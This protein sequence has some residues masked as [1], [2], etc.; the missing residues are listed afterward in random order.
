MKTSIS[1]SCSL[2]LLLSTAPAIAQ[3]PSAAPSRPAS[4]PVGT[5][6]ATTTAP[7]K[8]SAP[9]AT[10]STTP[11]APPTTPAA[12]ATTPATTAPATPA[13]TT[14]RTAATSADYRLVPGD[15]LR[16]EVYKDPQLSQSVQ[17]RPDGKITLP[18][19]NDVTAAGQTPSELRDAIVTS[20]KPYMSNPT[21]T[22]MVVETVP[23]LIY[24]MGE[25]NSA[26][27]QPLVGKMDVLQALAAAK[28]FRDFADTKNIVI[29]RGSQVLTFNYND[30]IKGK[31]TPVYLQPGD[32]IVVK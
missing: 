21:V 2:L 18:L 16:I 11:A 1:C 3:T 13:A 8:P 9:P 25:V 23:P 24:V 31:A 27:P 22:V 6:G 30:G 5:S 17:I 12:P 4:Q 29:R 26:G 15:K 32:T 20:L 14:T 7:S 28:G 19:A 10:P